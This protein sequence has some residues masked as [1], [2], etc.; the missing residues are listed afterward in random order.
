MWLHVQQHLVQA[1]QAE[2][3]GTLSSESEAVFSGAGNTV[4]RHSF[5]TYLSTISL[6]FLFNIIGSLID[7]HR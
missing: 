5:K 7:T 1:C 2:T 3:K 6:D 4:I